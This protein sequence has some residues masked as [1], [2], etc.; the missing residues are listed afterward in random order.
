MEK[1]SSSQERGSG[2]I[3][4]CE[5]TDGTPGA[6]AGGKP[7]APAEEMWGEPFAKRSSAVGLLS[8][9]VNEAPLWIAGRS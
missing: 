4:M 3:S 1:L 8:P 9:P 5:F 2:G 6:L 7:S